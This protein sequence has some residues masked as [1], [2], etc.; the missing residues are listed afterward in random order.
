MESTL[1]DSNP[2]IGNEAQEIFPKRKA[3]NNLIGKTYGRLTV[4][5][6]PVSRRKRIH[7]YCSCLCKNTTLVAADKILSGHTKSCGCLERENRNSGASVTHGESRNGRVSGR[8]H[9]FLAAKARAKKSESPFTLKLEHIIIP[10]KCP[11]LGIPLFFGTGKCSENSPSLD[12][13]NA[14]A[15]YTPDNYQI[16]SHKANTM[17]SNA[18][19]EQL[20]KLYFFWKSQ[21]ER[22]KREIPETVKQ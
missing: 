19:F 9:M 4:V 11:I 2:E 7:W 21:R 16:I 13:I 22:L 10:D 12:Q 20:E 18:T 1:I 17:K 5:N 6:G 8:L 14:G 15:G 3:R